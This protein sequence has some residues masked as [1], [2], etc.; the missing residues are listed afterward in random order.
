MKV[1]LNKE[2]ELHK[3]IVYLRLIRTIERKDIQEYLKGKR[4]DNPLIE[5]RV[6]EYLKSIG[7]FD[8]K[9]QLTSLG[10]DVKESGLLPTYE[11]GKYL[12][13]FTNNDSYF[14]N[15]I[16]YFKRVQPYKESNPKELNIQFSNDTHFYLPTENNSFSEFQLLTSDVYFGEI[17]H[18]QDIIELSWVWENLDKSYFEFNLMVN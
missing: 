10:N 17:L 5:N 11:E 15:Q 7:V 12:I 8:E 9:Y 1:I 13:W 14:G 2:I 16:F 6:K 3:A 4:F 18:Q